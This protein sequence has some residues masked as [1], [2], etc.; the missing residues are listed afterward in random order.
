MRLLAL[1]LCSPLAM[2]LEG[3]WSPDLSRPDHQGHVALG[4]VAAALT[5]ASLSLSAPILP[6]W[7]QRPG[8]RRWAPLVGSLVAGCLKEALDA[9][10]QRVHTVERGDITAT[11]VGGAGYSLIFCFRF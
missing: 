6:E 1:L 8:F 9:Q 5:D 11:V 7:T 3:S 2:A 4:F 10:D